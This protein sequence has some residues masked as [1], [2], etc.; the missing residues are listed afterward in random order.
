MQVTEAALKRLGAFYAPEVRGAS[1]ACRQRG[2]DVR[3]GY[4]RATDPSRRRQDVTFLLRSGTPSGR[5]SFVFLTSRFP[6]FRRFPPNG[7]AL[8]PLLPPYVQEL[9]ERHPCC[10]CHALFLFFFFFLY[11]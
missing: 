2:L 11:G 10:C 6:A 1:S 8:P 5:P 3:V 4:A 9:P 7:A